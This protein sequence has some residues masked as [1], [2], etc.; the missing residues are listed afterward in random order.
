LQFKYFYYTPKKKATILWK[1]W[2]LAPDECLLLILQWAMPETILA[3]PQVSDF[4]KV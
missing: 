4:S 1:K 3:L 2:W